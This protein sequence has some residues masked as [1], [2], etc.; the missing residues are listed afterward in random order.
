[1]NYSTTLTPPLGTDPSRSLLGP[2]EI[3]FPY[4][5]SH[6]WDKSYSWKGEYALE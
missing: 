6:A 3:G 4:M 2:F 5:Y 1:M